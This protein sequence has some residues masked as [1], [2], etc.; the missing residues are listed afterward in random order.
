MT[1][2]VSEPALSPSVLSVSWY[3]Y[4]SDF[5]R[6]T[7]AAFSDDFFRF[8]ASL[9]CPDIHNLT[10]LYHRFVLCMLVDCFRKSASKPSLEIDHNLY[11]TSVQYLNPTAHASHS[12][13]MT[14]N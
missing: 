7:R 9:I 5:W 12:N 3:A 14:V 10:F 8:D 13:F 2:C 11:C 1:S 4:C 6:F